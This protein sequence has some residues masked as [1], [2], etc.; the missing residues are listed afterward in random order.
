VLCGFVL[1][2]DIVRQQ[3]EGGVI[4]SLSNALYGEV[5]LDEGVVEQR[6]FN[7]Y[8][9]LR[10]PEAPKSIEVHFIVSD[11]APTGIGEPGSLPTAAALIN[12]LVNATGQDLYSLPLAAVRNTE[13]A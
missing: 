2:P 4:F 3:L 6:N 1:N 13:P 12:A 9:L 5:T 7:D 10:M 8:R 11:A